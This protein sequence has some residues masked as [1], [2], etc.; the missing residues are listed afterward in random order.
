MFVMYIVQILCVCFVH[1]HLLFFAITHFY[2]SAFPPL[3]YFSMC[4]VV[5]FR[6]SV[7]QQLLLFFVATLS[8]LSTTELKASPALVIPFYDADA[9]LVYLFAKVIMPCLLVR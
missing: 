6:R 9:C 4:V 1:I 3:D 5:C 7:S 2:V 8:L